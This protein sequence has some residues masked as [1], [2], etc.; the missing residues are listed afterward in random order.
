MR[1]CII[2]MHQMP[3]IS[4]SENEY[5]E[6]SRIY[7]AVM[8]YIDQAFAEFVMGVRSLDTFEEYVDGL[9]DLGLDRM[10]E[11]QQAAYERYQKK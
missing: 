1:S 8:D 5:E 3:L 7:A 10:L 9:R 11:I 4:I 2:L 6:Y